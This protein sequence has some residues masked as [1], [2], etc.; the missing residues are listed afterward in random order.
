M[1]TSREHLHD[2]KMW[3]IYANY[4]MNFYL[5]KYNNDVINMIVYNIDV[6]TY[7]YLEI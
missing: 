4:S 7:S 5:L 3:T 6:M 1:S 2:H